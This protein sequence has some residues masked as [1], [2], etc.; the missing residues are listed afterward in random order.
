L[1]I[2]ASLFYYRFANSVRILAPTG[3][4][5]SFVGAIVLLGS[6]VKVVEQIL[7]RI[8]PVHYAYVSGLNHIIDKSMVE[9][10]END[11]RAHP[12]DRPVSANHWRLWP[13]RQFL[14]RHTEQ[15]IPRD[16]EI[17]IRGGWFK[18]N[19]EQLTFP[20]KRTVQLTENERLRVGKTL[21]LNAMFGLLYETRMRRI[22]IYGVCSLA[23]GFLFQLLVSLGTFATSPF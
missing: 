9:K 19:G 3:L 11:N 15:D 5:L 7:K 6:D 2:S 8:D 22:Y 16:A 20:E 13:I 17:D 12:Y 1:L 14:E 4:T 18:V 23:L 21:S 10:E